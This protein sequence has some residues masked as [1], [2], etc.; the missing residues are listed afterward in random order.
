MIC[1]DCIT[2]PEQRHKDDETIDDLVD[3][4][5]ADN[6]STEQL[7]VDRSDQNAALMRSHDLGGA[8]LVRKG[9]VPP[10]LR[11]GFEMR[12]QLVEGKL[13]LPADDD[14]SAELL[15]VQVVP[16][17]HGPDQRTAREQC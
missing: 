4:L 10:A 13:R 16:V 9:G 12:P 2:S 1:A 7:L 6:A 5:G 15:V 11:K 8:H 17:G 3:A 14:R